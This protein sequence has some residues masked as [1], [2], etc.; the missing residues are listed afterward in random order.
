MKCIK[1]FSDGKI[2]RV[3]EAYAAKMCLGLMPEGELAY[4]VSKAEWKAGGRKRSGPQDQASNSI[5]PRKGWANR[6]KKGRWGK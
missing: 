4:Y 6:E 1:F 3:S 2:V 5:H